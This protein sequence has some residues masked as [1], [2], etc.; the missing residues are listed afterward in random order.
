MDSAIWGLIGTVV[1]ALASIGSTWLS[2]FS[3][4]KLQK[5]IAK[6]D[7]IERAHAFQRETLL[8]L[9][10]A[11]HDMLRLIARAY[12]HD[13]QAHADGSEWGRGN[14]PDELSEDLRLA[15]RKMA[16]L[17]ERVSDNLLRN[18]VKATMENT[19]GVLFAK[20]LAEAKQRFSTVSSEANRNL[21]QLGGVLRSHY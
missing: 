5:S 4:H 20:S 10:D 16:I 2:N 12:I 21:E 9:Q 17:V 3:A 8:S 14:L 15:Q 6:A 13:R 11:F 7:H 1:G 19:A 18:A